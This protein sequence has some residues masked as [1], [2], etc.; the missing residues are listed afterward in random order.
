MAK[1]SKILRARPSSKLGLVKKQ[2]CT[3]PEES[4][5]YMVQ[6]HFPGSAITDTPGIPLP[7][8]TKVKVEPIP[9]ITPSRTWVPI[10]SFGPHK[11]TSRVAQISSSPLFCNTFLGKLWKP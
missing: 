6:E 7:R 4:L 3:S 11:I 2:L 8:S 9:W 5:A 1:L 10:Y